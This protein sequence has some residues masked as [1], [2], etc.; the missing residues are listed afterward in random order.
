MRARPRLL[1]LLAAASLLLVRPQALSQDGDRNCAYRG[2]NAVMPMGNHLCRFF[3]LTK[4]TDPTKKNPDLI[5]QVKGTFG[6][7]IDARSD[8]KEAAGSVEYSLAGATTLG[9]NFAQGFS[10]TGKGQISKSGDTGASFGLAGTLSGSGGSWAA[11]PDTKKNLGSSGS[12][13]IELWFDIVDAD[14]G[15]VRGN[16]HGN[17]FDDTTAGLTASGYVAG[18]RSSSWEIQDGPIPDQTQREFRT[19]VDAAVSSGDRLRAKQQVDKLAEEIKKEHG[20]DRL[21]RCLHKIWLEGVDRMF[22]RWLEED[23]PSVR[24]YRGDVEGLRPLVRRILEADTMMVK[25]GVDT[26]NRNLHFQV[27]RAVGAAYKRVLKHAYDTGALQ[28]ILSLSKNAQIVG[29]VSPEL[30]DEVLQTLKEIAQEHIE[31]VLRNLRR[32]RNAGFTAGECHPDLTEAVN[33][34]LF[35]AKQAELVGADGSAVDP[36]VKYLLGRLEVKDLNACQ[37]Q[38]PKAPA[39]APPARGGT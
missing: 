25:L 29:A 4:Y 3:S 35:A 18:M 8:I 27:W 38:G 22:T 16:L 15:Q 37:Q 5:L 23:L 12:G 33:Q 30:G 31:D 13:K 28:D 32:L 21:G 10:A 19:R 14:C 2:N 11:G 36:E 6:L 26:C 34:A 7:E 39:P 17:I 1:W 24:A 9:E 20:N